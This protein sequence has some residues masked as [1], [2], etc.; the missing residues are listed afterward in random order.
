M[1]KSIIY[2]GVDGTVNTTIILLSGVS[3]GISTH[4]LFAIAIATIVAGAIDMA[5]C[6]YVSAKA[7]ISYVATEEEREL[8]EVRNFL[9]EEKDE[10]VELY[11]N[12]GYE[13]EDCVRLADL[14]ATHEGAFVNIMLL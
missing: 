7:E 4:S 9:S 8:Y 10:I 1:L 2:G 13:K 12:K 6:D 11:S 14:F 3:S 5:A